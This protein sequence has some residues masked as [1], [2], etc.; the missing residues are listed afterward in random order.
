MP[1]H[2]D[3]AERTTGPRPTKTGASG[4]ADGLTHR[5][6]RDLPRADQR[7]WAASY[8]SGLL[9]T[10]GKKSVRNMGWSVCASGTAAQSL[11]QVVNESTWSWN[12]VRRELAGWCSERA[13]VRGWALARISL[14]KR[15]MYSAGVHRRFDAATGRTIGC[16]LG[17]GLF[18][19]T[20][21]GAV[22]VD[23]RLYLPEHWAD[24]ES[25][26]RRARIP[27]TVRGASPSRLLLDLAG[28]AERVGAEA[29]LLADAETVAEAEELVSG[30]GAF[31]GDW[32]VSVPA[33][34]PVSTEPL[35]GARAGW[36]AD[37]GTTAGGQLNAGDL[38]RRLAA[39]AQVL[40]TPGEAELRLLP[41]LVHTQGAARPLRVIASWQP[42]ERRPNRV[43][44]TGL[45]RGRLQHIVP[46]LV[47]PGPAQEASDLLD[48]CGMRDFEGRS[49]PGWHRHMTLVAAACAKRLLGDGG[50]RSG[51]WEGEHA[52]E[53]GRQHPTQD[54]WGKARLGVT[55][56][57]ERVA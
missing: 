51:A 20:D 2:L 18:L 3:T 32:A 34:T 19:L 57:W 4:A 11:H 46:L 35:S 40:P 7:R 1:S 9:S 45:H 31:S 33:I 10:P 44:L 53:S 39:V 27:E 49:F 30:L 54:A 47:R 12:A 23:W 55:G 48:D 38:V 50:A 16:Q 24:D 5:L 25:L 21:R 36:T 8:V 41:G 56:A 17:L 26:R 15:G 52:R 28:A 14:P 6:F 13:E 37:T 42:G 43:W 29:P 22:P